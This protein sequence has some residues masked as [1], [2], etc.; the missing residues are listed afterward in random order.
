MKQPLVTDYNVKPG[1]LLPKQKR[2]SKLHAVARLTSINLSQ[3]CMIRDYVTRGK[4]VMAQSV[5][6]RSLLQLRP[7]YTEP[8]SPQLLGHTVV[9]KGGLRGKCDSACP[10]SR[11]R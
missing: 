11:G 4:S 3:R 5:S 10:G 9:R 8:R 2:R 1:F 6:D 7:L